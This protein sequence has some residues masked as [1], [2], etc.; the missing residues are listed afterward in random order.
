[1]TV[2]QRDR[3]QEILDR[4]WVILSALTVNLAGGPNGPVQIKA[5][6]IVRNRNDLQ[7]DKTPGMIILDAD[8]VKDPTKLQLPRGITETRMPA[9]MMKMTPE[10]YIVMDVRPVGN[11]NMGQDLNTARLAVLNAIMTDTQLQEIVGSNGGIT[12]DGCVTD[13]ARNRTMKGQLGMSVTFSYPL[14]VAEYTTTG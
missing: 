5:G 9:Q 6:S 14:I 7:A 4:L 3:R 1:M 8:E 12:Y 10:I 11:P 13:L 2:K